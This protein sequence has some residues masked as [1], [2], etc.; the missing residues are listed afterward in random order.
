MDLRERVVLVTGGAKRIGRAT[1]LALADR[2]AKVVIHYSRSADEAEATLREVEKRGGEA[3]LLQADLMDEAAVR[4]MIAAATERFGRVDILIN[5]AAIFE[6]GGFLD[7]TSENWDRHFAVNLKAPFLLSQD[8]A[9]QIPDEGVGKILFI[10]DWRGLRPGVGHFA[11]T[12]TKSALVTM[13]KSVARIAAP[14]I[15]TNAVALGAILPPEGADADHFDRKREAIPLKRTGE[16]SDVVATI[17]FL[18]EGGDFITGETIV[19]DG[20]EHL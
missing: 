13:T 11:Y 14:R 20:G 17:L 18:L 5:N 1:V 10:T 2:G 8:F 19:V 15:M 4:G 16:T 7:T 3:M 6:E 12:L 9:R